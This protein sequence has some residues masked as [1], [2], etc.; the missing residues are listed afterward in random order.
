MQIPILQVSYDCW[1]MEDAADYHN[2]TYFAGSVQNHS[3]TVIQTLKYA[4]KITSLFMYASYYH[5][6]YAF[7]NFHGFINL[8]NCL[9]IF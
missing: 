8:F 2:L 6:N 7:Y 3:T 1:V 9:L 5:F 4:D